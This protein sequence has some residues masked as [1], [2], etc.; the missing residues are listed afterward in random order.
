MCLWTSILQLPL[1]TNLIPSIDLP[2]MEKSGLS[3]QALLNVL[4]SL[5]DR[6]GS[7]HKN[8]APKVFYLSLI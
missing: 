6:V 8:N 7:S 2:D 5:K 1:P 3:T 4:K